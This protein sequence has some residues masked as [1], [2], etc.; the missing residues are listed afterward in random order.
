IGPDVIPYSD[1]Q[2]RTAF[3][4]PS[5]LGLQLWN[6]DNR[7]S[8]IE[9]GTKIGFPI[10]TLC[11][12]ND[13]DCPGTIGPT[14]EIIYPSVPTVWRWKPWYGPPPPAAYGLPHDG[15]GAWDKMLLWGTR[16]SQLAGLSWLP[17]NTPRRVFM[18]GGSDA[19][20]DLNYRREGSVTGLSA[21]VD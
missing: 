5:V 16:P 10:Q 2:L 8:S 3:E 17:A 6:E 19:H 20:G 11:S 7:V 14:G 15:R 18:A 13:G 1:V 12:A 21:A 9:D 4:S